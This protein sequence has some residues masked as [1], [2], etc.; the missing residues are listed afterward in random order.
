MSHVRFSSVYGSTRQYAE[1]LAKR[2]GCEALELDAP[3]PDDGTPVIFLSPAHGPSVPAAKAAKE[4]GQRGNR[5]VAVA[6]VGMT[7][8]E[9]ARKKDFLSAMVDDATT[10]FYLPGR[11]NYSELKPAHRA[12]MAGIIAALR[13][14]PKKSA[15]ER[16]MID[17]YNKDVDKVE[18][19]ELDAVVDWALS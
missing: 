11:L 8:L 12:T 2:L 9:E 15:N 18:L 19:S 17:A 10:R 14:K 13:L 3:V 5:K 16:A 4:F 7:I 1:A 6:V